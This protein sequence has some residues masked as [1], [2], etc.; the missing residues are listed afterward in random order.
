MAGGGAGGTDSR[1]LIDR[2]LLFFFCFHFRF[3][4]PVHE[5]IEMTDYYLKKKIELKTPKLEKDSFLD[6]I[7]FLK[8]L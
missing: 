3:W 8:L 7:N 2:F 1:I 6:G 5:N 4:V